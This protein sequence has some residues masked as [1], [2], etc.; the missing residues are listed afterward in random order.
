MVRQAHYERFTD[1]LD[2]LSVF[3][4]NSAPSAANHVN[5]LR[6]RDS[7]R[8]L[9]SHNEYIAKAGIHSRTEVPRINSEQLLSDPPI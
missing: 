4:T 2:T 9:R 7:N 8:T 5:G 6:L 1:L 3:F